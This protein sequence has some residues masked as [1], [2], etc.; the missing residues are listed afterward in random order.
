MNLLNFILVLLALVVIVMVL[1]QIAKISDLTTRFKKDQ[2]DIDQ[3]TSDSLAKLFFWMGMIGLVLFVGFYFVLRKLDLPVAASEM[4]R[5]FESLL[6]VFW[7][8]IVPVFFLTQIALFVFVRKYRFRKDRK[9]F[10]YPENNKLELVWTIIPALAMLTLVALGLNKWNQTMAP[11]PD[12][13]IQVRVTGQQ[14]KWTVNYPGEDNTFGERDVYKYGAP[15]NVISVNPDD[16]AAADDMWPSEIV[17][18]VNKPVVFKLGAMDV[19]HNFYLPHFRM[20]MDC[21]P[22][23]PTQYWIVPDKTTKEMREI[24]GNPDFDYEAACAEL[25]GTG[26][27]NMKLV[28]K[29]VPESEYNSWLAA[30]PKASEAFLPSILEARVKAEKAEKERQAEIAKYAPAE[31]KTGKKSEH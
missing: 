5:S 6:N 20:K 24:T 23:V 15:Y 3:D 11:P 4:G 26:H 27:W 29:V 8:F 7:A 9:A 19:L 22:G 13:A 25:C 17:V 1:A 31:K 10:Y 28:L 2:D 12:D 14:F 18:P 21:V 16:P 30:Q